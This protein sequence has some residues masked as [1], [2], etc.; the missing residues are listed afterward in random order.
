MNKIKKFICK[1]ISW[2]V[3]VSI[4]F[5]L[6]ISLNIF[7]PIKS[8]AYN[9]GKTTFGKNG[10]TTDGAFGINKKFIQ[11]YAGVERETENSN[12][13]KGVTVKVRL[14]YNNFS[15]RTIHGGIIRDSVPNGFT[16][17]PNTLKNCLIPS[18]LE[19]TC[20]SPLT[21]SLFGVTNVTTGI[22]NMTVSPL[23]GLYDN[24]S[25]NGAG[26]TASNA[27]FGSLE[28]GKYRYIHNVYW[29]C[30]NADST[31]TPVSN[32]GGFYA[33]NSNTAVVISNATATAKCTSLG[34]TSLGNSPV[35]V[36]TDLNN[37]RYLQNRS[38]KC[39]YPS[40]KI[41]T[42][43]QFQGIL[44]T[45]TNT[46]VTITNT[47]A[48]TKCTTL[49]AT[50]SGSVTTTV[51]ENLGNNTLHYREL[52]CQYPDGTKHTVSYYNN[53]TPNNNT[54][55]EAVTATAANTFCVTLGGTGTG[56]PTDTFTKISDDKRGKGYIEYQMTAPNVATVQ[57]ATASLSLQNTG[58]GTGAGP[59]N[60]ITAASNDNF[61][62][63]A[64][65][66]IT[67]IPF[68]AESASFNI[69]Y[70]N[71]STEVSTLNIV[72]NQ[73]INVRARYNNTGAVSVPNTKLS[74]TIPTGF[75]I[76]PGS[77]S[78]CLNP[79]ESVCGPNFTPTG[80]AIS[81]NTLNLS[82]IMGLYDFALNGTGTTTNSTT[83]MLPIGQKRYISRNSCTGYGPNDINNISVYDN[84]LATNTNGAPSYTCPSND[85]YPMPGGSLVHTVL[86]AL[87][88]AIA[89]GSTNIDNITN[90]R[91][92]QVIKCQSSKTSGSILDYLNA[93][94]Y[95]GFGLNNGSSAYTTAGC[96]S[97]I[98]GSAFV[99]AGASNYTTVAGQSS[100][101]SNEIMGKRYII[102]KY[103][104]SKSN[105]SEEYITDSFINFGFLTTDT[106]SAYS[107]DC[108]NESS[109]KTN[110]THT[111]VT[112][113]VE[114]LDL[115][116]PSRG[117]GYIQFSIK[118]PSTLSAGTYTSSPSLT[119]P[120]F[121]TAG[122]DLGMTY[123]PA[124]I[125]GKVFVDS[126]Y[127]DQNLGSTESGATNITVVA[128]DSTTNTIVG[129]K[130]T[131]ALDSTYSFNLN[132]GSY[133]LENTSRPAAYS[134]VAKNIGATTTDNDFYPATGSLPNKTDT[135]TVTTGQTVTNVDLGLKAS[136]DISLKKT[137]SG[138][139]N[140]A[141]VTA[142]RLYSNN[143]IYYNLAVTNNSD[144][145]TL[146]ATTV[147]DTFPTAT[148]TFLSTNLPVNWS[149]SVVTSTIT[150]T[151][152]TSILTG[153]TDTL[154]I[155]FKVK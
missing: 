16:Y 43:N 136:V 7:G 25:A 126:N 34:A 101:I 31:R 117:S 21:N 96:D 151:K 18:Y 107:S 57:G 130:T 152:S 55:S 6:S 119:S 49:G 77:F 121:S 140:S 30:I 26:G 48:N 70:L 80:S 38:F 66:T 115:L 65:N 5:G 10:V 141:P 75:T 114:V 69:N 36:I 122:T 89:P 61:T 23:A 47:V 37:K 137:S 120:T 78:N 116:E 112:G 135:F 109:V 106:L 67:V 8:L 42:V 33:S 91:F 12:I 22:T 73:T 84:L 138:G 54:A 72:P 128:K 93:A 15:D 143:D 108:S 82:P 24:A 19:I 100:L 68:D 113:G 83:G 92:V 155:N 20:S 142:G 145:D 97:S 40:G 50:L 127:D 125:S 99:T 124:V 27:T 46:P 139:S 148:L 59:A 85:Y 58:I 144:I 111:A 51:E 98:T 86:S 32:F 88:G 76:N 52:D 1:T 9:E 28:V 95:G 103:C 149:C 87:I 132:P 133:Y 62:S 60:T 64:E 94:L 146:G 90:K 79:A 81:G 150:C 53:L 74:I 129:S 123:T 45:A 39:V 41:T 110:S 3:V 102:R 147:T 13:S 2:I 35:D 71:G 14:Y 4:L 154:K 134:I 56:T 104:Q 131:T 63:K 153:A 105:T 17:I 44:A 29:D 11:S 118:A